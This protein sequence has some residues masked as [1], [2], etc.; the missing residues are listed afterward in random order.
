[1]LLDIV[2]LS[3]MGSIEPVRAVRFSTNAVKWWAQ[4]G[5]VGFREAS[6]RAGERPSALRA[7]WNSPLR[8]I[9]NA[10]K[11]WAQYGEMG[12]REASPQGSERKSV[13]RGLE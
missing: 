6:L 10:V 5:E 11:W 7:G 2:T 12:F 1:M 8:S 9:T 13:A 4:Y 3:L